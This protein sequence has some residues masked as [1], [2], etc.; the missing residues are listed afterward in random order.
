QGSLIA[1]DALR[2]CRI[3]N[4][5]TTEL[6]TRQA[7]ERALAAVSAIVVEKPIHV[8]FSEKPGVVKSHFAISILVEVLE[9]SPYEKYCLFVSYSELLEKLKMSMNDSTKSQAKA[10]AYITRMK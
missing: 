8:I 6:K 1:V 4:Y 9:R 3:T 5:Q 10:Q 7:K 2:Q